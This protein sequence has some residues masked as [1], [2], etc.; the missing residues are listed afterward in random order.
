MADRWLA[1]RKTTPSGRTMFACQSCGRQTDAPDKECPQP[2]EVAVGTIE[3]FMPCSMW[4]AQPDE[5]LKIQQR[6]IGSNIVFSGTIT[7]DDGHT[8]NVTAPIHEA[9]A[10]DLV[11]VSTELDFR[12]SR[13]EQ[14]VKEEAEQKKSEESAEF[15]RMQEHL[16]KL[17]AVNTAMQNKNSAARRIQDQ[18]DAYRAAAVSQLGQ[19]QQNDMR[20]QAGIGAMAPYKQNTGEFGIGNLGGG[21]AGP[22]PPTPEEKMELSKLLIGKGKF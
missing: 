22:K 15:E 14:T 2:V 13:A 3:V 1:L 16:K 6:M 21:M 4:P 10:K 7:F 18:T 5:W 12:D 11:V 9:L 20:R 8:A 19:A 17:Q